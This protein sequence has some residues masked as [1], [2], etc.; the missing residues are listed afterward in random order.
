MPIFDLAMVGGGIVGL[1]TAMELL[2]RFPSL[3]LILLEKERQ[4]AV[5]QTSHNSGVIH[6]G[7]YYRPGSLKARLC[8]SGANLLVAFC[9][10]HRIPHARCGKLVVATDPSEVPA[11]HRLYERGL[12]NGVEGLSLI[13]PERLRELEP[14]A[15]GLEALHVASAGVVDYA[16]VARAYAQVILERGGAIRTGARVTR[17]LRRDQAWRLSTSAGEVRAKALITCGGL[18]ADRLAPPGGSRA[19]GQATDAGGPREARIIPFRGD[20]YELVP[21]RRELVRTMIYP[22][23]DPRL[24]FLGV[25]VTRGIDGRVHAGP[26]AVLALKR[27]GYRNT[28][29]SLADTWGL[30][31]YAGFWRMAR[32][33]WRTGLDELAR[34]FSKRAFVRAL[35]RL[36]PALSPDDFVPA[37]SGVRAQAVDRR[38]VLL[39]DF[40][41]VQQAGA[42]QVLN[43]PS[44]AATASIRIGQHLADMAAAAFAL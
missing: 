40:E 14:H 21:S 4:V 17:V 13:G 32:R 2:G 33:H 28:D 10:R 26:N 41:I 43:V 16:A 9:E 27:E 18:H 15:R 19:A 12:A 35:Q 30:V 3:R 38:G 34:S 7:L 29:I 1:A 24:P 11:L 5:H 22:V 39:D 31:G 44:P 6:S 23:P 20:Y 37:P 42:I 25:H 36:V 8:V